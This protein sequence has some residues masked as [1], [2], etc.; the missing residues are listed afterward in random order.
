VVG[1]APTPTVAVLARAPSANGK[2]RLFGALGVAADPALAAAL[3]LDTLDGVLATRFRVLV[4]VE[5]P[6][7][8]DEMRALVPPHVEVV[9]QRDGDLGVRMRGLM[10]DGF[11][12]GASR[13]LLVG[14]D[15]PDL[16]AEP[17]RAAAEILEREPDTVV[18]GPAPDGGYYLVAATRVPDIFTGIVWSTARVLEETETAARRDGLVCRRVATQRDVDR[19][20]DLLAVEA[21]RTRAWVQRARAAG[22]IR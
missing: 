4:G 19:V 17:L 22:L 12:R 14:S 9:P 7:A 2:A 16:S 6:S 15:L 13:V 21:T 5:P 18:L 20:S 10:E 11:A 8:L 3:L 1:V